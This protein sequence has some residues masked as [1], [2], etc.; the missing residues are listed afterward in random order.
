[1]TA[2]ERA[3]RTRRGH[4]TVIGLVGMLVLAIG[5]TV[6]LSTGSPST[7]APSGP[8]EGCVARDVVGI[9]GG[10]EM[11]TL[12]DAQLNR[13]LD[14][15]RSM[16]AT[17]IRIGVDWD[18]VEPAP[19][20]FDW[21]V[22]DRIVDRARAKGF[23]VLG[24]VLDTPVWARMPG[25][26]GSPHGLP[27]DPKRFGQF[28]G[29]AAAHYA[30]R[31]STWEIWNE[32]NIIVFAKP[33]PDVARYHAMLVAAAREIRSRT[34][35]ATRVVTGGL[36]PAG[37][38][39]TNISPTTFLAELYGLGDRGSW[40][41][42]GMHPYTYPALPDDAS[43]ASW[44]AYIRMGIS[45]DIMRRSGDGAKQIWITEFGAPTGGDPGRDVSLQGQA[46][47]M[48]TV[49]TRAGSDPLV[50]PVIIHNTRDR[51]SDPNDIEDHFGLLYENFAPKPA[52]R[53]IQ[54][55]ARC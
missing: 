43:T 15:M 5:V 41:A 46:D 9:A 38:D 20:M 21:R 10:A 23:R 37:D 13:E 28:A 53:A 11:M 52:Y 19:G 17:W 25:G 39:G 12:P 45:R 14:A 18:V 6:S 34:S 33:R 55:I 51:G 48:V 27:A 35:P 8:S 42:V 40:D 3:L 16:G 54:R 31:I 30:G 4:L 22:P 32:P 2:F 36:A 49:L 26:G 24:L 44:N 29:Q 7:S 47:A 50:G 1:M